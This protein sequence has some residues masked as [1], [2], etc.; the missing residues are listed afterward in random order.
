MAFGFINK[1]REELEEIVFRLLLENQDLRFEVDVFRELAIDLCPDL[2]ILA[3]RAGQVR[4]H[5]E[6]QRNERIEQAVRNL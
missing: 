5:L 1:T 3:D 4:S 2:H 6:E